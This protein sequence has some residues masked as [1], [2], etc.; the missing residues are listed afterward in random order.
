[1]SAEW[2]EVQSA[3]RGGG[4]SR[5]GVSSR[6]FGGSDAEPYR[7]ETLDDARHFTTLFDRTRQPRIVRVRADGSREVVG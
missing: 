7:F 2:Y 6:D 4:Y 3:L 5:R 1:M